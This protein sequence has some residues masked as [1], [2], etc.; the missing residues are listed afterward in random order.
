[1]SG[2][3]LRI[4]VK[5]CGDEKERD[6][7]GAAAAGGWSF[8]GAFCDLPSS[9]SSSPS[10]L[11]AHPLAQLMRLRFLSCSP[12]P[13]DG[14]PPTR[15]ARELPSTTSIVRHQCDRGIVGIGIGDRRAP[16]AEGEGNA[17]EDEREDGAGRDAKRTGERKRCG[18]WSQWHARSRQVEESVVRGAHISE[19]N[20]LYSIHNTQYSASLGPTRPFTASIVRAFVPKW[21]WCGDSRHISW[22]VT[23]VDYYYTL[24][25]NPVI[26]M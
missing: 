6:G 17:M 5:Y 18:A 21:R 19:S 8:E 24:K 26:H 12:P 3:N 15:R 20:L 16:L 1:M 22:L 9:P 14:N 11:L 13:A 10:L 25:I 23:L 7:I 4:Y 2:T